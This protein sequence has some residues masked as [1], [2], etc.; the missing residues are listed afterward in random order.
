MGKYGFV[1]N[2]GMVNG[3]KLRKFGKHGFVL[4]CLNNMRVWFM[5]KISDTVVHPYLQ[6]SNCL[7]LGCKD[8]N[9]VNDQ[10]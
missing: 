8:D 10:V 4:N 5:E 2:W 3:Q 6:A 1:L 7:K 9:K